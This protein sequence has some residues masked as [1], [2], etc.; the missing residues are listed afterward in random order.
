[1]TNKM[2]KDNNNKPSYY[3]LLLYCM[4]FIKL[5]YFIIFLLYLIIFR[6]FEHRIS[7]YSYEYINFNNYH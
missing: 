4:T 2:L 1:M 5:F 6:Y 7:V 3:I